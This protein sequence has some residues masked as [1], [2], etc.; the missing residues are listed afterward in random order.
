MENTLTNSCLIYSEIFHKYYK[1]FRAALVEVKIMSVAF[2]WLV[3]HLS[4]SPHIL[5]DFSH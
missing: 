3:F 2:D 1:V 4:Y 5:I